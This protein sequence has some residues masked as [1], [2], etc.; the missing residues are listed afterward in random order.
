MTEQHIGRI[1]RDGSA[2]ALRTGKD[3]MVLSGGETL[4]R[5]VQQTVL[6]RGTHHAGRLN[7]LEIAEMMS[8]ADLQKCAAFLKS[9]H[10]EECSAY[11]ERRLSEVQSSGNARDVEIWKRIVQLLR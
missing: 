3:K 5:W 10:G 4:G 9:R 8:C 1:E 2:W 7:V 6:V 11:A